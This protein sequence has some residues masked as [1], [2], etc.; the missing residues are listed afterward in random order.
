MP[1]SLTYT[2][3][4]QFAEYCYAVDEFLQEYGIANRW[5][6]CMIDAGELLTFIENITCKSL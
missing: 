3:A 2:E 1:Q 5:Q 4:L 6:D